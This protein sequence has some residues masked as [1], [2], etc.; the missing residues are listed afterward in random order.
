MLSIC[1]IPAAR[2]SIENFTQVSISIGSHKTMY[3][4]VG[5]HF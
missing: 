1:S 5:D 3:H 4:Y 2:L